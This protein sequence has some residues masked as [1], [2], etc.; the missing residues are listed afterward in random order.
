M[1]TENQ[2]LLDVGRLTWT[3]NEDSVTP[4][5]TSDPLISLMHMMDD[6]ASRNDERKILR[7]EQENAM[8]QRRSVHPD[9]AILR[10]HKLASRDHPIQRRQAVRFVDTGQIYVPLDRV[11]NQRCDPFRSRE[12]FDLA[13]N[14][15]D[16]LRIV[17]DVRLTT[18][19]PQHFNKFGNGVGERRHP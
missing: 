6:L 14:L 15:G 13:K 16:L 1:G 2:A 10:H 11:G 12:D 18:D 7:D 9:R 4:I 17:D 19:H 8:R 5:R 3:R